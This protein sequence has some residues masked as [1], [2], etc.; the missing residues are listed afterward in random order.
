MSTT[1]VLLTASAGY[2]LAAYLSTAYAANRPS[3]FQALEAFGRTER[4]FTRWTLWGH[5][6]CSQLEVLGLNSG[7]STTHEQKALQF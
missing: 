4:H 5:L 7:E 1:R 2:F 3:A 6:G